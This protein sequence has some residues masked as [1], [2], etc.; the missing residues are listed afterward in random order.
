MIGPH[1]LP[2]SA[3]RRLAVIWSLAL[4][5]LVALGW[6]CLSPT[7]HVGVAAAGLQFLL[8]LVILFAHGSIAVGW[9]GAVVFFSMLCG[10]SFVFEATSIATGIPFGF[11]EHH[12]PGPRLLGV[13]LVVLVGYAVYGWFAWALT[14]TI[15]K[16]LDGDFRVA[17]WAG[18][19]VAAFILV[20]YDYPWDAIGATVM[21]THSYRHPSGLFGVPLSNFIGWL[22]TGWAAF[23]LVALILDRIRPA[24]LETSWRWHLLAP[25]IWAGLGLSYVLRWW[26]APVGTVMKGG[27]TFVIADIFEASAAIALPAMVLPALLAVVAVL[28]RTFNHSSKE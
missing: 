7:S 16:P 11:F 28:A 20:G 1:N 6:S 26:V 15:L 5:W 14:M 8:L 2:R 27:R 9:R 12:S 13:P 25:V 3:S 4:V 23:Q 10:V 24:P 18:P 19:I 22:V 17:R 21:H